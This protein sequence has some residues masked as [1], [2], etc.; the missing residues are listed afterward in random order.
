MEEQDNKPKYQTLSVDEVKYKTILT[1]KYLK[2]KAYVE[3]DPRLI[4]AFIPGT[5]RKVFV[6]P[7][8]KVK[9]GD[10]LLILDAMKMNNIIVAPMDSVVK[11]IHA[12]PGKTVAKNEL[13]IELN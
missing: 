1:D 8:S 9:T 2:R 12:K 10:K 13:L 6:K 3:K 4:T 11:E 7:G 5:I